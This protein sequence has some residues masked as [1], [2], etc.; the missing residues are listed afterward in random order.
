MNIYEYNRI[1]AFRVIMGPRRTE[2]FVCQDWESVDIS[3]SHIQIM[4][5]DPAPYLL[6]LVQNYDSFRVLVKKR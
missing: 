5:F 2:I 1:T 3:I 4:N 6:C